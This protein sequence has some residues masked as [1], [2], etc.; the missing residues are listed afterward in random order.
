[1]REDRVQLVW[2]WLAGSGCC[3][4]GDGGA[5]RRGLRCTGWHSR[6]GDAL[7]ASAKLVSA[8][9]VTRAELEE[10]HI[11]PVLQAEGIRSLLNHVDVEAGAAVPYA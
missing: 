3:R 10:E 5:L 2:L 8:L 7:L 9:S 1:M 4:A 6:S 11:V